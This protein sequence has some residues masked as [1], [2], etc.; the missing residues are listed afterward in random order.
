[1]YLPVARTPLPVYL[2]LFQAC[3]DS[4]FVG[5]KPDSGQDPLR[6]PN[7]DV[8]GHGKSS[9]GLFPLL[10]KETLRPDRSSYETLLSSLVFTVAFPVRNFRTL[11]SETHTVGGASGSHMLHAPRMPV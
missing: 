11:T 8:D 9:Q 4:E 1:M 10:Q 6:I 5:T 3:F 7:W 2:F